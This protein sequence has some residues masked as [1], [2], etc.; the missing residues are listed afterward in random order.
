MS[1][2]MLRN[3]FIVKSV[4]PFIS[5]NLVSNLLLTLQGIIILKL[6]SPEVMGIWI[7]LQLILNYG[8]Q[9]HFGILNGMSRQIPYYLGKNDYERALNVENVSRFNIFL[10]TS[11]ALLVLSIFYISKFITDE[12]NLIVCLMILTTIIRLNM[13]FHIAIFKAKQEFKKASMVIGWEAIL[14]FFTLPLVYFIQLEGLIL[15]SFICAIL[16][17]FLSLKF[18]S[19]ALSI[20]KDYSLTKEIISKGFPIMVLG[21]ALVIYGSMDRL[22][23]I[24]FLDTDSLGIYSIGL[25]VASILSLIPAF[26]GQSF[27]PKMVET[28][29]SVGISKEMIK[30]C[31]TASLISFAITISAAICFFYFLPIFVEYFL[32]NYLDGIDAMNIVLISGVVLSL[33]AGPNYFII[34]AEKKFFQI[35]LI[36]LVVIVIAFLS[37]KLYTLDLVGILWSVVFGSILYV[38]GLWSIVLYS[39]FNIRN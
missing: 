33:S 20:K 39:Y 13:E 25:A 5:I 34:A 2:R 21:F 36:A 24:R 23:I 18:N 11:V 16:L 17:L 9:F 35:I 1:D 19:Y 12:M 15:R 22:M 8:I 7:A 38:V 3:H 4:M 27:Y 28:F 31:I 26:S 10:F 14:M 32:S 29:S 30:I 6:V 37:S